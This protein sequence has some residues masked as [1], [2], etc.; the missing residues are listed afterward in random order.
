[1]KI[2]KIS[3][4]FF[5]TDQRYLAIGCLDNKAYVFYADTMNVSKANVYP[6]NVMYIVTFKIFRCC[7]H[8]ITTINLLLALTYLLIPTSL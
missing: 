8:F 2:D 7:T 5:S 1:M 4:F 3:F 6:R